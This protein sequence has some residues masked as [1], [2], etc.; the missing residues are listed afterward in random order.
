[1]LVNFPDNVGGSRTCTYVLQGTL[2]TYVTFGVYSVM[3]VIIRQTTRV[4]AVNA[5]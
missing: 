3:A 1:M 4:E 2:Y 5:N